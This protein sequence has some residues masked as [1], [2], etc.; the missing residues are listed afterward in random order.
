LQADGQYSEM[1]QLAPEI[2]NIEAVEQID[3]DEPSA[4][5]HD[6]TG[7]LDIIHH[8]AA[9]NN[10]TS[11]PMGEPGITN[12]PSDT[13]VLP[14]PEISESTSTTDTTSLPMNEMPSPEDTLPP[15]V[16][17]LPLMAPK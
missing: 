13:S 14:Q 5:Y 17:Q 16:P 4:V 6:D 7:E 10:E 9:E 8:S 12:Q 1:E 11:H 3:S 15:S 2:T